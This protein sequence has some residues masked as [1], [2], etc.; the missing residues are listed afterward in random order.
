M[1]TRA[2]RGNAPGIHA[3]N[4]AHYSF[5]AI[6]G[7]LRGIQE[8]VRQAA[9][10]ADIQGIITDFVN[11]V[12]RIKMRHA[13]LAVTTAFVIHIATN[14][15]DILDNKAS[16]DAFCASKGFGSANTATHLCKSVNDRHGRAISIFD[17]NAESFVNHR[18]GQFDAQI[19]PPV[20]PPVAQFN[21]LDNSFHRANERSARRGALALSA[22]PKAPSL[23]PIGENE[24]DSP[25]FIYS[26]P[27]DER[28]RRM[29]RASG[30][31]VDKR[32][33]IGPA[34]AQWW[35]G[36]SGEIGENE[37]DTSE[38]YAA[39]AERDRIQ[40]LMNALPKR[41]D[42]H[43][44]LNILEGSAVRFGRPSNG[45]AQGNINDAQEKVNLFKA[46]MA[47]DD[48]RRAELQGQLDKAQ[49]NLNSVS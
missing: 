17:D 7:R 34:R 46:K 18:R 10:A 27:R 41:H 39:K 1:S 3:L 15:H 6:M 11:D 47:I 45:I 8:D 32:P 44:D 30:K 23:A 42:Q 48:A 31:Q 36:W 21:R 35:Q 2:S 13:L 24:S 25:K 4:A 29:S 38:Y 9:N 19:G 49:A 40:A 5:E 26:N 20:A 28:D 37:P 14:T 33:K 22:P 43:R 12:P 16:Q